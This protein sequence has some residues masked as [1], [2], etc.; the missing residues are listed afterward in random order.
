MAL[1]YEDFTYQLIVDACGKIE[2]E[3]LLYLYIHQT[4]LKVEQYIHLEDAINTNGYL[5][6]VS[7]QV[8]LALS[9]IGCPR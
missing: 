5:R 6:N 9:F 1:R 8:I 4:E 3:W 7:Q 2:A